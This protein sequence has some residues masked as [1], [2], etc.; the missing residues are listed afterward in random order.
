[1]AR[2]LELCFLRRGR[3]GMRA[4]SITFIL[5]LLL[6]FCLIRS[7]GLLSLEFLAWD[8]CGQMVLQEMD[9]D[10]PKADYHGDEKAKPRGLKIWD[11]IQGTM[12]WVY[13][14]RKRWYRMNAA[15]C[16]G[17]MAAQACLNAQSPSQPLHRMSACTVNQAI[18]CNGTR[19][20]SYSSRC[21]CSLCWLRTYFK[22]LFA[23]RSS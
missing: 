19:Q 17:K 3:E 1:M 8:W 11:P 9:R 5:D 16:S 2:G 18:Y 10:Q 7:Q 22:D 20:S 21:T 14:S 12:F 23:C 6:A 15:A 13:A 4:R